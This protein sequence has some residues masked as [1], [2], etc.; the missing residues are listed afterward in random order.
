MVQE[1]GKA[2]TNR[3][4][5]PVKKKS[6][7]TDRSTRDKDKKTKKFMLNDL[8]D[9]EKDQLRQDNNKRKNEKRTNLDRDEKEQL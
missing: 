9:N 6:K 3:F 7:C 8:N 2:N 4:R 1:K 5:S